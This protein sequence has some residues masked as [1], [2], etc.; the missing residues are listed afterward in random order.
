MNSIFK[1]RITKNTF[2]VKKNTYNAIKSIFPDNQVVFG[3]PRYRRHEFHNG[4]AC[5]NPGCNNFCYDSEIKCVCVSIVYI[6]I[7]NP[8][9]IYDIN[10]TDII[11]MLCSSISIF[12][13]I[14]FILIRHHHRQV[15]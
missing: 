9:K 14:E 1:P 2:L 6:F 3:T 11:I 4:I 7:F 10:L 8:K 12:Y 13:L 5:D 15:Q